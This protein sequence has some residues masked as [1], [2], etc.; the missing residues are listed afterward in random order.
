METHTFIDAWGE[1]TLTLE[2]VAVMLHL[3][4]FVDHGVTGIILIKEEERIL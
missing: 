3:P 4:L 1:F 2:D